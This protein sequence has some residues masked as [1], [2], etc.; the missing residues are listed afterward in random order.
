MKK[1]KLNIL[2]CTL[3]DGGYYNNWY[4]KKDLINEYL[5]VMDIIKVDY[6]EIGFRFLDKVKIK[7]PCAYSK[8]SFLKSLKIP[9]NL[10][11]GVMIN[12]ADFINSYDMIALAKKVFKPKK[13]VFLF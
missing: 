6:V 7:G 2:D 4:F 8:E 12:A 10:K 1:N 3:R 11:L 9:K 5:R 13:F